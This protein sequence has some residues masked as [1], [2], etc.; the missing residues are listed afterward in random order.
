MKAICSNEDSKIFPIVPYNEILRI[1]HTKKSDVVKGVY[2]MLRKISLL[3]SICFLLHQNIAYGEDNQ[4]SIYE[5]R[6]ALYKETEQSS[7]IPWYYLAAMDQYER[8]IR[9]VRKDI[10][11]N[12]MPSFP[13]ISNQK[14]GL[15]I[16]MVT[17][18]PYTIALFGG[19]GLDGDKDGFANA[20][21][22]RDLLHTAATIL[23]KQ[24]TS[25]ERIK[26]MLWEYYRRAKQLI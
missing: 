15:D 17:T 14:Y 10:P 9:S 19:L 22:D 5:K 4:Q 26:I 25:E 20:N 3:L 8:N 24:G 23:K 6:M 12:Q 18:L 1:S 7:G 2:F 21:N 11:K 16:L 13:F